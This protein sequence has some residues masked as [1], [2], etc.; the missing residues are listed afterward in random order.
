MTDGTSNQ[1][2]ASRVSH[3]KIYRF[4]SDKI[5]FEH[6]IGFGLRFRADASRTVSWQGQARF[7]WAFREEEKNKTIT[8]P[9]HSF[10]VLDY[11]RSRKLPI[12][13]I[14]GMTEK[15]AGD[16]QVILSYGI[17]DCVQICEG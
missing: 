15:K 14:S 4:A 10:Q 6:S 17:N 16:T 7:A 9:A 8:Q 1:A 13:F 2:T 11:R 12:T 5:K 3:R